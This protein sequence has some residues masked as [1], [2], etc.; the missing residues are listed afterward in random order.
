MKSI[1]WARD[2]APT[3]VASTLPSLKIIKVG[4]PRI[5]NFPGVSLLASTSILAILSLPSYWPARSSR[6]GAIILQGP[7]QAAQKSTRTGV[8]ALRTSSA[9]RSEEHTSELQSRENF[10]CR[11]LFEIKN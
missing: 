1:S 7:H 5:L 3:L 4:I 6:I 9:K 2:K 11:L 10:V 8:L